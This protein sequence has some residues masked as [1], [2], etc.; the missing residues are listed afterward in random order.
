MALY[1][2][3]DLHLSYTS[4]KP[5]DIFGPQWENHAERLRENWQKRVSPDDTVMIAGDVSWG[6][7]I[8][9]ARADLAFI[10]SLNGR[11]II[12]K[13]N[14]DFWWG[15]MKK[16]YEFRDSI[17]AKSIDFLFNNAYYADGFVICGS[18]GWFPEDNYSPDDEKIVNREAQRLSVSIEAGRALLARHP[19]SELIVFLHYPLAY[20]DLKCEKLCEVVRQNGI[21]RVFYG[22]IHMARKSML[23]RQI[24]GAEHILTAADFLDFDPMKVE[25]DPFVRV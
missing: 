15:T 22:H 14:H 7:R 23:V 17:G 24:A 6:M 16:L 8:D 4:N 21:K 2:I 12:S 25:P 13:G 19:G 11:K 5:M 1:T 9:D 20:G 18:R 3:A 10:E